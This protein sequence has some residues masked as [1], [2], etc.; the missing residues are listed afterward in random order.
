MMRMPRLQPMTT[1]AAL[2][3]VSLLLFVAGCG[4]E[5]PDSPPAAKDASSDSGGRLELS[6]VCPAKIVV[7]T[8]WWPTMTE[9]DVYSLLGPNPKIDAGK[10][11]VTAPLFAQGKET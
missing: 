9:G 10:K 5:S 2:S 11:R 6:A 4:G 1:S 7:Q 3:G 8:S